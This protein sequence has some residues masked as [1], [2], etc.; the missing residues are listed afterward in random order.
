MSKISIKRILT[1][2]FKR[3]IIEGTKTPPT[4]KKE[5]K[6][7]TMNAKKWITPALPGENRMPARA[8]YTP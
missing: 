2:V 5:R 3:L 8:H 7:C 4:L 6:D 1:L